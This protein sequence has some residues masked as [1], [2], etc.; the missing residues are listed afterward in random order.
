MEGGT[1]GERPVKQHVSKDRPVP[2]RIALA[3]IHDLHQTAV[4]RAEAAE[5]RLREVEEA[6]ERDRGPGIVGAEGSHEEQA[7]HE[8]RGIL[9]RARTTTE[10]G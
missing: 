4:A 9:K 6:L 2:F 8:A 7:I 10:R 1:T 5:Q 3:Y